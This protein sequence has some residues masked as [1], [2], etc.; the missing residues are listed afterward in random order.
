MVICGPI[1]VA[2]DC[3]NYACSNDASLPALNSKHQ[4]KRP[5]ISL[6]YAA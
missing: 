6:N 3:Y 2:G 1:D 5:K 4:Q